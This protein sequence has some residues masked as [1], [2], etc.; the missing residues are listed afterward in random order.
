MWLGYHFQG[1]KVTAQGHQAALLSAALTRKVAAVA[2]WERIQR[3]KLLVRCVCSAAR[4]GEER[5]GGILCRVLRW[6]TFTC[7]FPESL[8]IGAYK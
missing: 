7:R 5:G 2:A 3:G 4:D 1:Q 6:Q 8:T